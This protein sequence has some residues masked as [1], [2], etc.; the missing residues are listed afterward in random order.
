MRKKK[1]IKSISR[2]DIVDTIPLKPTDILQQYIREISKFPILNR[3]DELKW[4]RLYHEKKDSQALKIL[5]KSNLRFVVK[6]ATEYNRFGSKLIDL[7]Q[8]GNIGLLKAINEFNP[9]KGVRLITYAV[10]WIRG[11][12]QEYLMRQHSIVRIGTTPKQ[13]KLFYLLRKE[14]LPDYGSSMSP[15]LIS[16]QLKIPEKEV[17]RM[18]AML[19]SKDVSTDHLLSENWTGE[20][21]LEDQM[22]QEQKIYWLKKSVQKLRPFLNKKE[23]YILN[24]RVL[25]DSPKTLQEI[26]NEFNITREAV[27]QLESKLLSKIKKQVHQ[28]LLP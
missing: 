26:G 11:A 12:I 2:P 1:K 27:R 22:E 17:E 25:S 16:N 5:I 8:E 19:S 28:K 23:I 9:Y 13:K 21:Q 7:I 15:S 4:S 24:H 3:E 20:S 6:I 18:R 10:W 14:G